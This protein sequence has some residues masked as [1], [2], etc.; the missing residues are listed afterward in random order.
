[1]QTEIWKPLWKQQEYLHPNLSNFAKR[2]LCSRACGWNGD[3]SLPIFESLWHG[4]AVK[5]TQETAWVH[6]HFP[7]SPS[8]FI[9]S[10]WEASTS[11]LH[12]G[13]FPVPSINHFQILLLGALSLWLSLLKGLSTFF[14]CL[15]W[16]DSSLY[17]RVYHG[18]A[19]RGQRQ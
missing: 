13:L 5:E 11:V 1:M 16:F 18:Q 7:P 6:N 12:H 19:L 3:I 8:S 9:S 15:L 4:T 14:L 17:S 2:K 10:F